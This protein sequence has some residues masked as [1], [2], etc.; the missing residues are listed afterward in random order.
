MPN[1]IKKSAQE[2]LEN[3]QVIL[4]SLEGTLFRLYVSYDQCDLS[5]DKTRAMMSVCIMLANGALEDIESASAKTKLNIS[6]FIRQ[7]HGIVIMLDELLDLNL[8]KGYIAA[9]IHGLFLAAEQLKESLETAVDAVM[10]GV[11]A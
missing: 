4:E 9:A 10:T 1:Q 7:S 6:M 2:L 3:A 8:S 5:D 11:A